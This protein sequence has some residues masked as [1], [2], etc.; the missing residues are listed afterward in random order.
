MFYWLVMLMGWVLVDYLKD[1]VSCLMLL[2]MWCLL[3]IGDGSVLICWWFDIC[4]VE[5]MLVVVIVWIG[6]VIVN[7]YL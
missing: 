4:V 5:C 2:V 1:V 7:L 3:L 6:V